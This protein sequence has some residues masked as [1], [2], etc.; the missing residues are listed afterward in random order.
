MVKKEITVDAKALEIAALIL[1]PTHIKG[2]M[3]ENGFMNL[4]RADEALIPY[5]GFAGYVE[6]HIRKDNPR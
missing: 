5:L 6:R 2:I 1:G 4:D 3:N